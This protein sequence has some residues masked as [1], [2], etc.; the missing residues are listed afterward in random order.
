MS[1]TCCSHVLFWCCDPTSLLHA[2]LYMSAYD[3]S[4]AEGTQGEGHHMFLCVCV[5][6]HT[7]KYDA[8][9]AFSA[10]LWVGGGLHGKGALFSPRVFWG[11][12]L[13]PRCS[14]STGC[15][16]TCGACGGKVHPYRRTTQVLLKSGEQPRHLFADVAVKT[17]LPFPAMLG[18]GSSHVSWFGWEP[19]GLLERTP[20]YSA[21]RKVLIQFAFGSPYFATP[22]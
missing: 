22:L 9:F 5:S 2:S 8:S 11:C 6:T 3:G 12:T 20:P 18:L 16:C 1:P 15:D 10:W 4:S 14:S 19:A 7:T 13:R 21:L 17:W